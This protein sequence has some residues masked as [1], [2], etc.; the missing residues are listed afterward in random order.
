MEVFY[1]SLSVDRKGSFHCNSEMINRIWEVAAD[2]F[3]LNSRE[4]YMDG[5]KRDRWVWSGDAYQSYYMNRYL[6]FDED[7]AR[8]TITELGGKGTIRQHINT[9]LDYTFFWIMSIYDHYEM[10]EDKSFLERTFGRMTEFLEFYLDRL[11]EDG[12]A[13][14]LADDWVFIDWADMDKTGAVCA[15]QM[16]LL[17]SLEAYAKCADILGV[18]CDA[19]RER[20]AVLRD[21]INVCYWDTEKGAF[22]DSFESGKR[23]VTRHANIFALLFGYADEQ[24]I[25]SI[26]HNVILNDAVP[27]IKTPY[28]KFYELEAM[29]RIGRMDYVAEQIESY[30]GGMINAGAT[31][32]WEE[33]TPD[34]APEKQLG[35]YEIKYGKS[36]CHAWGA[37]PI[38]LIGRYFL[39]VRPTAPAYRAFEVCPKLDHF[40]EVEAVIPIKDGV[41]EMKKKGGVL[42]VKTDRTG[43]ILVVNSRKYILE[44]GK[45]LT[46]PMGL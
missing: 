33:Y 30:W 28:F 26:I 34:V 9:I 12:L 23:N 43:G 8:R 36:L 38:Y 37:S 44:Q 15:E 11:N 14:G 3:E 22:I 29:C 5:I 42:K 24:Q 21:K 16:L 45:E 31:S 20:I 25:E 35:M 10:T 19:I 39:G 17:R 27:G 13:I 1:E 40:D 18:T 4:F 46:I 7:I 2:T 32:F 6:N 41:V